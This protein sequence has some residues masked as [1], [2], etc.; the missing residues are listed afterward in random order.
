MANYKTILSLTK[1]NIFL[2][3]TTLEK[4]SPLYY[5]DICYYTGRKLMEV[6]QVGDI[7]QVYVIFPERLIDFIN[8]QTEDSINTTQSSDF[9]N[10]AEEKKKAAITMYEGLYK[11]KPFREII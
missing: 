8:R 7:R 2:R 3:G 4:N 5:N 6:N 9:R 10:K 11:K 1:N